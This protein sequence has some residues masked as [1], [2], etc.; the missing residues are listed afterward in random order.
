[1]RGNSAT[2][3]HSTPLTAKILIKAAR[4]I[5]NKKTLVQVC[6]CEKPDCH[7]EKLLFKGEIEG[8]LGCKGRGEGEEE[9][10]GEEGRGLKEYEYNYE[11]EADCYVYLVR[12]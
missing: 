7:V 2:Y 12:R 10:E 9:E 8:F 1:M 4:S 3:I 5:G 11:R 6:I